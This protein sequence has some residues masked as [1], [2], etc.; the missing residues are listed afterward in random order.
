MDCPVKLHGD[1]GKGDGLK[2]WNHLEPTV[3]KSQNDNVQERND[4]G[5]NWRHL[6]KAGTSKEHMEYFAPESCEGNILVKPPKE[7]TEE[8]MNKW[9]DCLVGFSLERSLP[10]IVVKRFIDL[11]WRQLGGVEVK[12]LGRGFFLLRFY[13]EHVKERVLDEGPWYI[14]GKPFII[15]IW[16]PNFYLNKDSIHS[17]P[18]WIRLYD[19]PLELWTNKGLS[20]LA[21]AIGKPRFMDA[22]TESG[23]RIEF[24]RICV[25]MR[26]D[27]VFPDCIDVEM[28]NGEKRKIRVEYQWRPL[29][30]RWC[31]DLSH[32]GKMCPNAP[33]PATKIHEGK[34][35]KNKSMM[36]W[37]QTSKRK[38][39]EQ[40]GTSSAAH[41]MSTGMEKDVQPPN[42]I[43]SI[44]MI[45]KEVC[46]TLSNSFALLANDKGDEES[47]NL[48]EFDVT[49]SGQSSLPCIKGG[50]VSVKEGEV[51]KTGDSHGDMDR[52]ER[53]LGVGSRK[54]S[55][56]V[57]K[58]G[59]G[60]NRRGS[61]ESIEGPDGKDVKECKEGTAI[62][63]SGIVK[64]GGVE[65]EME[66]VSV[67]AVRSGS[68][69]LVVEKKGRYN[70]EWGSPMSIEKVYGEDAI[71]VKS[72]EVI[73]FSNLKRVDEKDFAEDG[74]LSKSQRRKLAKS[75]KDRS[76]SST[77]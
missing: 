57:N 70:E 14:G 74:K 41:D 5:Q 30:C 48:E 19:V 67:G 20:Y 1:I 42:L 34:D 27:D 71:D 23:E 49:H 31:N 72:S 77:Q 54:E 39:A 38:G 35:K 21:S 55:M 44:P 63:G 32:A 51:K 12:S 50:E 22:I 68:V 15:K 76:T 43:S 17:L 9:K 47:D 10:F 53:V 75:A 3:L 36:I 8:G 61:M 66:G 11:R 69:V 16:E 73:P 60:G 7:V 45:E 24:A 25:D 26:F 59:M 65:P 18:I 33:P 4:G 46:T 2:E 6:F 13:D 40:E 64:H 28:P 56:E 58:R 52:N 37:Q 62:V 29:K